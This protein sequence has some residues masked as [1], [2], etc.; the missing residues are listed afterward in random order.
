MA[1]AIRNNVFTEVFDS[2]D[3]GRFLESDNLSW[4]NSFDAPVLSSVL[5]A[6]L[7][8]LRRLYPNDHTSTRAISEQIYDNPPRHTLYAHLTEIN[9]KKPS[10]ELF[11]SAAPGGPP[12]CWINSKSGPVKNMR[13]LTFRFT[14]GAAALSE[15]GKIN[16][17]LELRNQIA[18]IAEL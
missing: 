17:L 14:K 9:A 12:L 16:L 1:S 7:R 6:L 10:L 4:E 13:I 5:T 8:P 3:F 15:K 11:M 2:I 18:E